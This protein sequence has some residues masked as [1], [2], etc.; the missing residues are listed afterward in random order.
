MLPA[1]TNSTTKEFIRFTLTDLQSSPAK[2]ITHAS[3]GLSASSPDLKY[4]NNS[5]SS[6]NLMVNY[7]FSISSASFDNGQML[8]FDG[9]C[10]A[11]MLILNTSVGEMTKI[12]PGSL[13]VGGLYEENRTK[14]SGAFMVTV[15]PGESFQ[16]GFAPRMLNSS[17]VLT[18]DKPFLIEMDQVVV[19]V[20]KLDK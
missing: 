1:G 3:S 17:Q 4:T 5:T 18:E 9:I 10:I 16:F 13:S 15:A 2:L 12:I 20:F 7:I 8:P 19:Q 14:L 6:I 11:C